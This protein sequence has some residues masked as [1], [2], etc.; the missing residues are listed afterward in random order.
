MHCV[1]FDLDE[2]LLDRTQSVLSFLKDQYRQLHTKSGNPSLDTWCSEFMRLDQR[3][4]LHKSILYPELLALLG[5]DT[6]IA[7]KLTE[8]YMINSPKFAQSLP[9]MAETLR[10]LRLRRFK[11]GIVTNG[12]TELQMRNIE[13]LGLLNLVDD[14]VVSQAVGLRKPDKEIF[15]FAA[16]RLGVLPEQ[17]VFVGDNPIVDI[18][19]AHEAGMK[20]IWVSREQKWPEG[21]HPNQGPTIKN[22]NEV[23]ALL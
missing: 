3:G 18:I 8:E 13:A 14:V 11:I 20:T 10:A 9:E 5:L 4:R 22:L 1:L 17:C 12:E 19:G 16:Q 21:P 7:S 23:F 6:A 15:I 2:T